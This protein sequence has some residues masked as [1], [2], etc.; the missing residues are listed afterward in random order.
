MPSNVDTSNVS[1]GSVTP[2]EEEVVTTQSNNEGEELIAGK[3]KSHE[4]LEK[5]YKE[6]EKKLGGNKDASQATSEEEVKLPS[7]SPK[8]DDADSDDTTEK[9]NKD[10]DEDEGA[11]DSEK[12][13][14]ETSQ[15]DNKLLDIQSFEQEFKDNGEL[16]EESFDALDKAGI[17]RDYVESYIK[18]LELQVQDTHNQRAS[19][20]NMDRAQYQEFVDWVQN[21]TDEATLEAL[22]NSQTEADF[23]LK[24]DGL[25][26]KYRGTNPPKLLKGA[27][28]AS[29]GMTGYQSEQ[30]VAR[31]MADPKYKVDP[32]F[33]RAVDNKLMRSSKV[34]T[35]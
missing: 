15:E 35:N 34:F 1:D 31:D 2:P 5:A 3:F 21:N 7:D 8:E 26:A 11:N 29:Y 18:G 13:E 10:T 30:E 27:P 17:P 23:R 16:S 22:N 6:L 14:E 4:D 9:D 19:N 25:S 28:E 24:L 32:A 12:E 33:R 20:L